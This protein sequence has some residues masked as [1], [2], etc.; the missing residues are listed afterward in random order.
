MN[1]RAMVATRSMRRVVFETYQKSD[2]PGNAGRT[3]A[4]RNDGEARSVAR[5]GI[6]LVDQN[7]FSRKTLGSFAINQSR[8][9][10]STGAAGKKIRITDQDRHGTWRSCRI[11]AESA[12]AT[13]TGA[14]RTSA[15]AVVIRRSS[16]QH[17][18]SNAIGRHRYWHANML[19]GTVGSMFRL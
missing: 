6:E 1:D 5:N 12:A 15:G 4:T 18:C 13:S 17:L 11:K 2:K 3:N 14:R 7:T 9:K 10:T 8:G 19:S 16:A